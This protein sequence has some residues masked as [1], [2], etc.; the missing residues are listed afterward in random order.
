MDEQTLDFEHFVQS[1]KWLTFDEHARIISQ[2]IEQDLEQLVKENES[3]KELRNKL[4]QEYEIKQAGDKELVWAEE[5]LFSGNVCAIDGT[6][7]TFP[8]AGIR[9][10]IGIAATS[11]KDR[12]TT[13]VVFISEQTFRTVETDV[14][15]IL[16]ARKT[17]NKFLTEIL[18]NAVMLYMERKVGLERKEEWKLINGPLI[19]FELRSHFGRLRALETTLDICKRVIDNKKFIG[20]IAKTTRDEYIAIGN[21]LH[22]GEYVRMGSLEVDLVEHAE[23]HHFER[24]DREKVLDFINSHGKNIDY[25][26]YR[27][28][29]RSYVLHAHKDV[30]DE[31]ARIVI[32][33][34]QFQQI[35]S[36]PMLIDYA[37]S[38]CS[39]VLPSH[40]FKRM[41][42]FKLAKLGLLEMGISEKDL[43]RR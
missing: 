8:V 7:S 25:G 21:A 29:S 41:M 12:K 3:L 40:D 24:T 1:E 38:L 37:D 35:R 20:V 22:R 10:R 39:R 13:G 43:R 2:T 34:S 11:Y 15:E 32:R 5:Q 16:K 30:F 4:Q 27:A 18:V 6:C 19:P 26:I 23:K 33:D 17:E 9:C 14:L 28:G 36:Y 31:A 42:E